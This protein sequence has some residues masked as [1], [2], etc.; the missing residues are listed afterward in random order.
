MENN[1]R[2]LT[3]NNFIERANIKHNYE[4]TYNLVDYKNNNTDVIIDCPIHGEFKQTP[5]NHLNGSKCPICS[6][7]LRGLNR[8]K[9]IMN[10]INEANKIHNDKYGY[11]KSIYKDSHTKLIIDCPIH[12]E[13]KQKPMAHLTLK[14]GCPNCHY[15][16]VKNNA[17]SW[18]KINWVNSGE[19]SI[20]FDSFK[21]YVI[22]CSNENESFYKVGRTYNKLNKRFSQIPYTIE[23]VKLITSMD[24][25]YIFELEK[26]LKNKYKKLKYIPLINFGGK[27]ECFLV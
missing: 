8:R 3:A 19:K 27:H 18:T 13:F 12:G 25:G 2:R 5:K 6:K 10:F 24:G 16:K 9:T 14:Q 26:R 23:V 4:Y 15:D 21:L 17:P 20:N 11:L 1:T 7:T 22:R